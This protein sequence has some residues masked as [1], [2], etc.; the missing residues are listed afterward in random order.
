MFLLK[1]YSYLKVESSLIY[2][3]EQVLWFGGNTRVQTVDFKK[4]FTL[5]KVIC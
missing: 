5:L 4:I 1:K 2:L 3:E